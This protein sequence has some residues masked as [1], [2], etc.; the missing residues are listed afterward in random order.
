[1]HAVRKIN[2]LLFVRNYNLILTFGLKFCSCKSQTQRVII[3]Y[4][5]QYGFPLTSTNHTSAS[6]MDKSNR[7]PFPG[8]IHENSLVRL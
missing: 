2:C 6:T 4:E 3:S 5:Y 8:V 1:M 7:K